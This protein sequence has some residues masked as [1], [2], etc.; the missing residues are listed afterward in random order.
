MFP[1]VAVLACFGLV[2]IYR[3]DE[4]LA[5]EQAQWFVV[6]LVLFAA[7]IVFLRDFRVLERY[8]YTVAVVGL[9]LLLLP[10]VPGIGQQVNGAYLGVGLGPDLVPAGGVREDRHRHLPRRVPARHAADPRP[11][12]APGARRD[13]PAAQALRAAARGLGRRDGP[14]RLHP[15]PRL[16]ADVLRRLPR[17]ALRGHEPAVVRDHRARHVRA[18]R[19]VL[20]LT[21]GH[22]QD[23]I[24]TWR[25]PFDRALYDQP[26]GSYQIAQSLFAQAD[27]GLFGVG[28]GQALIT[29]PGGGGDPARAADRPHLRRD[30]Q[31][32]RP[33]RRL[34]AAAR[35]PAL[36]RARLQ[37]RDARAATRSPSCSPP[38]SPRCSRSRSS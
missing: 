35:L 2:I 38:A 4:E 3:I 31:R 6:G 27:G 17:A 34:R 13:D 8:R 11:G 22:V 12:L 15:R 25:D 32:A 28:F 1:L 16:V 7:T 14:A 33:R 19:V 5:R 10:R 29:Q 26:G 23:R 30:R 20:R 9:L 21:V 37:D 18:R 24:D 36:R